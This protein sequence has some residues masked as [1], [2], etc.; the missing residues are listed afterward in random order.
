MKIACYRGWRSKVIVTLTCIASLISV[1]A[2]LSDD[3]SKWLSSAVDAQGVRHRG[4]EYAGRAPWTIDQ[5]KTVAPQYPYAQRTRHQFGSGLFRL[6]LDLSTGSV[7]K[8]TVLKSTGVPALDNSAADA[9]RQWRW[10]PGKWKGIDLPI[11][12]TVA[13]GAHRLPPGASPIPAR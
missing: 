5:I 3:R 8:V 6:T 2:L 1:H 12:F 7:V 9:F 4:S 13:P 11:T 10:K